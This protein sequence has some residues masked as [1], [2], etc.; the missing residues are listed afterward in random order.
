MS[1]FSIKKRGG[2]I[3]TNIENQ[4]SVG[5]I[6]ATEF[7][8]NQSKYH[9]YF[10]INNEW[11]IAFEGNDD[12]EIV[13]ENTCVFIQVKTAK[14]TVNELNDILDNFQSHYNKF[15]DS[16]S[17]VFF[18]ISAL[19][20]FGNPLKSFPQKLK[21]Y[22]NAKGTYKKKIIDDTLIELMAE[23][24]INVKHKKILELLDID[25]RYLIK[26]ENDTKAIFAH[27]LRR[28][29]FIKDIGDTL[30]LNIY[31]TMINNFSLA[32]RNRSSIS[33]K[34]VI[35]IIVKEIQIIE[36]IS[37][38]EVISGYTKIDYG[39]KK[40]EDNRH[41]KD[42]EICYR[43]ARKSIFKQWRRAYLKEFLTS[44]LLGNNNCPQCNHPLMANIMGLY[45]IACPDCGFQP[46]LT[47]F[48]ACYCGEVIPI[49][50]QPNLNTEDIYNYLLE[51]FDDNN[52][53]CVKCSRELIDDFFIERIVLA[54]VPYPFNNFD[55][56]KLYYSVRKM[57]E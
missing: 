14:I 38:L 52:T 48:F 37:N 41:I 43:L 42:L 9:D 1:Y 3:A 36:L 21:E 45:G 31:D 13:S 53:I 44:L 35:N 30:V 15:H 50:T 34:E 17:N 28:A 11:R 32:R 5:V 46:Y 6:L 29:Y 54:P 56:K 24:K 25:T 40:L 18:Q 23:Y 16:Y 4:D 51:Y 12:I 49:K 19:E 2:I 20:G 47:M 33:S 8:H 39:Y 27:N 7:L 57:K 26:D 22:R 55:L 10:G